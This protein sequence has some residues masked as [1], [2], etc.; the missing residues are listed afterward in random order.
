MNGILVR[1]RVNQVKGTFKTSWC[2]LTGD[3]VGRI[4]GQMQRLLGKAQV[5]YGRTVSKAGKRLRKFTRH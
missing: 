4:S 5:K 1:G 2:R 3:G